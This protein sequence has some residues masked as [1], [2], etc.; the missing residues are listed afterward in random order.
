VGVCGDGRVAD[1][2]ARWKSGLAIAANAVPGRY[3]LD[4]TYDKASGAGATCTNGAPNVP[5][6]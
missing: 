4:A 3:Q 5:G 6:W 2:L 1:S